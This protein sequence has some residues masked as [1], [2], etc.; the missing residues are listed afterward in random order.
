MTL[1]IK[2]GTSGRK[3]GRSRT[4]TKVGAIVAIAGLSV[5]T[6]CSSS[7]SGK[8]SSTGNSGAALPGISGAGMYG[9]LPA[10]ASGT[11]HTGTI[12]LAELSGFAINYILPIPTSA[13]ANIYND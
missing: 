10:A 1:G 6:A 3:G 12:K 2:H 13:T 4:L 11:E 8:S 5:L 7:S 9:S